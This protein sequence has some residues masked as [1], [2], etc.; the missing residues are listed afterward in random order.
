M[1]I[2]GIRTHNV[3][4]QVVHLT[5]VIAGV[6]SAAGVKRKTE[7]ATTYNLHLVYVAMHC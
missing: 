3:Q 7:L 2:T 1:S 6:D 5:N 4:L